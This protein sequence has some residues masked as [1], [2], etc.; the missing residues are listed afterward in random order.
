MKSHDSDMWRRVIHSRA[1]WAYA[2]N[3]ARRLNAVPTRQECV[4]KSAEPVTT[5]NA[6]ETPAGGMAAIDVR[7][8]THRRQ[9]RRTAQ[10]VE[11]EDRS[12]N[13]V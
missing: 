6:S 3:Q 2:F 13:S 12:R 10:F 1:T 9:R 11:L 4:S 7:G 5:M 8:T